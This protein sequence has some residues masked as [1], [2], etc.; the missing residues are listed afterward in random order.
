MG[1]NASLLLNVILVI[2]V[3]PLYLIHFSSDSG[4]GKGSDGKKADS[5][6]SSMDSTQ[7]PRDSLSTRSGPLRVAYVNWDTLMNE[8]DYVEDMLAEL[9]KEQ[10]RM[11]KELEGKMRNLE[12]EYKKLKEES[13][14]MTQA[15]L[16]K[17]QRRMQRK[18]QQIRQKQQG[19]QGR[20]ARKRQKMLNKF[21][22]NVNGYLENYNKKND[23]DLILRYQRGGDVLFAER[24]FDITDQVLKGLNE[25]YE[26]E[27]ADKKVPEVSDTASSPLSPQQNPLQP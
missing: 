10:I 23:I 6:A 26:K 15:E 27:G 8:Y 7:G 5:L 14:Y 25:K 20:L 16:K 21:F 19:L 3:V 1:K 12:Q 9:E 22:D 4:G 2:A 24:G 18:Q 13:T 11:R 17:A